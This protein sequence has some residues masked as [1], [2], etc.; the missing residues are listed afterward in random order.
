MDK[1]LSIT[2][3]R[4]MFRHPTILIAGATGETDKVAT[5]LLLEKGYPVRT[6]VHAMASGHAS[7]K[8]KALKS[9]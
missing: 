2:S 9:L 3:S 5:K 4:S 1:A 7:S 6:F 8:P